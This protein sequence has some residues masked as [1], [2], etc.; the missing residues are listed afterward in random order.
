MECT[1]QQCTLRWGPAFV[2]LSLH[3]HPAFE[4]GAFQIVG[5]DHEWV[6]RVVQWCQPAAAYVSCHRGGKRLGREG[7]GYVKF[8]SLVRLVA[9]YCV[10]MKNEVH[11]VGQGLN[12]YKNVGL[13]HVCP[14]VQAFRLLSPLP[15]SGQACCFCHS[16]YLCLLGVLR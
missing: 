13:P 16:K 10:S 4:G 5:C 6:V 9:E 2:A 15:R 14:D 1:R 3:T 8:A 7:K 12:A 11:T